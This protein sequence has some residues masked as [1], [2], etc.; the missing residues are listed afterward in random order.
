MHRCAPVSCPFMYVLHLRPASKC[1][2]TFL[3]VS[4]G[5]VC[6]FVWISISKSFALRRPVDDSNFFWYS[7]ASRLCFVLSLSLVAFFESVQIIREDGL[8]KP[9]ECNRL[10][11]A[12]TIWSGRSSPFQALLVT[13]HYGTFQRTF[14][15]A[16][17][18]KCVRTNH[19]SEGCSR[20][21]FKCLSG[22]IVQPRLV[23]WAFR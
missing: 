16:R 2:L 22:R 13:W 15:G 11:R 21:F 5:N 12:I 1:K 23:A 7:L 9:S 18:A 4:L 14:L 6:S 8:R 10:A 19:V 3:C 17:V 20:H